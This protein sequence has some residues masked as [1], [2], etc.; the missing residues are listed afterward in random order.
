MTTTRDSRPA[1]DKTSN[2][3][4]VTIVLDDID[5]KMLLSINEQNRRGHWHRK[6]CVDYWHTKLL[7]A[8][9]GRGRTVPLLKRARIVATFRFP[10]G[11]LRDTANL[12]PTVKA[13]V[14]VAVE[15]LRVLPG[16]DDRYVTEL[17]M[18]R[19]PENGPHR[20]VIEIE[21]VS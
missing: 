21:A 12:Y 1:L 2:V 14:D 20:V 17:V 11:H 16:D 19:D 7:S 9:V 3:G 15:E 6:K 13:L 5:P 8:V 4:G 10:T 18:R